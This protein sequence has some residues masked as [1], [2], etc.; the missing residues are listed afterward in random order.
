MDAK[1]FYLKNQMEKLPV[2]FPMYVRT[3]EYEACIAGLRAAQ[4]RKPLD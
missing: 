3:I 2:E 1:V 4:E